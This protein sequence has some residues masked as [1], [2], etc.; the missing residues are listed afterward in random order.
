MNVV[1]QLLSKY[2]A[3]APQEVASPHRM[4]QKELRTALLGFGVPLRDINFCMSKSDLL[5]LYADATRM[6]IGGASIP[7]GASP[8]HPE[9][10]T[11][12][13]KSKPA[14][15]S[16]ASPKKSPAKMRPLAIPISRAASAEPIAV[17][18]SSEEKVGKAKKMT[19]KELKL[20]LLELGV[21]PRDVNMC[22]SKSDMLQLYHQAC[23]A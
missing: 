22:L 10:T 15:A 21:K 17:A 5:D 9:T 14:E 7:K 13:P 4:S 2:E 6:R 8:D 3:N 23:Q 12:K 16:P 19:M 20:A 11:S 18:A 1:G